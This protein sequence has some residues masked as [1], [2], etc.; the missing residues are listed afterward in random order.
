MA[1]LLFNT[2]LKMNTFL[3]PVEPIFETFL[4]LRSWYHQKELFK[5]FVSFFTLTKKN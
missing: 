1:I 2:F 4:P 5:G 3:R